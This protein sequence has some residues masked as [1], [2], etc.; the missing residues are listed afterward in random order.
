MFIEDPNV[1][2]MYYDNQMSTMGKWCSHG[3]LKVHSDGNQL[4]G[5]SE[6]FGQIVGAHHEGKYMVHIFKEI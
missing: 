1:L 2:S 6:G 5:Q 3:N 4:Q